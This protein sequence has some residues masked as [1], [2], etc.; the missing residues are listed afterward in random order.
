MVFA[1]ADTVYIIL[2]APRIAGDKMERV[3][4]LV[5]EPRDLNCEVQGT[6][7]IDIEWLRDGKTI[8]FGGLRGGSSYLQVCHMPT[9]HNTENSR[10]PIF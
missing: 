3:E 1:K 10:Q 2:D 4:I 6:E 9:K 7:P 5:S 8:D